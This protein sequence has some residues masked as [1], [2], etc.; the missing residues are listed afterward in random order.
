MHG[1]G[2]IPWVNLVSSFKFYNWTSREQLNFWEKVFE[3]CWV[4]MHQN[5]GNT[6]LRLVW[7]EFISKA[8]FFALF[9]DVF[10]HEETKNYGKID[11]FYKKNSK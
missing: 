9:F 3:K 11:I 4:D 6:Y 8:S 7:L 2:E 5:A 1:A 10:L